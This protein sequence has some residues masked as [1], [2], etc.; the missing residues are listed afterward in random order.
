MPDREHPT[1]E[2]ASEGGTPG[3]LERTDEE[4][5]ARG[6]EATSTVTHVDRDEHSLVR[7]ET[8]TEGRR[9]PSSGAP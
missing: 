4:G 2:V 1:D 7:D 6:S 3:N 9:T 5:A 8:G